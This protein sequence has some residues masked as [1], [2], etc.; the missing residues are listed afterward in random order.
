MAYTFKLPFNPG[1]IGTYLLKKAPPPIFPFTTDVT[2]C[3]YGGVQA[4]YQGIRSLG[5]QKGDIVL[6]PAYSCGSEV[7]PLLAA[8]LKVEYYRSLLNL[9]PDL[10][11][12][13]FLC[14]KK[15]RALLVIHYFGFPQ[16]MRALVD[17]KKKHNIYLIEDNAHGLYST[18]RSGNPLGRAGDIAIFSFTKSLPTPD[19]G[20]LVINLENVLDPTESG[21]TPPLYPVTKKGHRKDSL[22]VV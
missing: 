16:P 3:W 14:R 6:V 12:L 21:V 8:G 1:I 20:A 2:S 7:T 9:S 4:I 13:E 17:F 19:G 18:D 11:H 10:E 15:P 22:S 5:L